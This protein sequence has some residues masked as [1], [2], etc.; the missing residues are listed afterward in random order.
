M[1]TARAFVLVQALLLSMAAAAADGVRCQLVNIAEWPVRLERNLPITEGAINGKKVGILIDTGASV[2]L[3]TKATAMKFDLFTRALPERMVGFGGETTVL[4]ARL[5]EL[6]IGDAARQGM[7]VRVGGER[8]IANVDFILGEDF[9][10]VL[11][12]EFDYAKGVIR[13]FQPKD[14]GNAWLAYWDRD[15]QVLPIDNNDVGRIMVPVKVNGHDASA[16][17]DSG[18]SSSVVSMGLAQRAG[19]TPETPGVSAAHCSQGVGADVV[20]AWVGAFDSVSLAGET[21]RDPRLTFTNYDTDLGRRH[22]DIILGTDFLRAHR[23]YVSRSQGKL[24]FSYTGGLIFPATP[25]IDCDERLAGK[26]RKEVLAA[27]DEAIAKDPKDTK[28]LLNRAVVRLA[29]N[30]TKEAVADLDAVIALEP[31][32]AVALAARAGARTALGDYDGA[33]ADS[34]GSIDNGMRTSSAYVER[35]RIRRAKGDLDGMMQEYDQAL[36]L[37]PL[38][39]AA[40]RQRGTALFAAGRFDAA[41]RDF[42]A[43]AA[44]RPDA[45]VAAWLSYARLR[46][47]EDANAALEAGLARTGDTPWP[48]PM[49][50]YLLGRSDEAALMAA[51]ADP[52]AARQKARECEARFAAAQRHLA[53]GEKAAARDL[54]RQAHESCPRNY[55]EYQA[56]AAELPRLQ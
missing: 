36:K 53:S 47:G 48:R 10:H 34:Q 17:L 14:C 30:E 7:R 42:A 9:L 27:L 31:R 16:M 44:A 18:A 26:D 38:D 21:I 12:V 8:P 13:L 2:S 11:D 32:N 23:V 55:Y 25:S 46:Q 3:L 22:P 50:L 37:D 41:E 39:A 49:L 1:K 52:D 5:D 40:L 33:L 54:L 19:V 35:A 6:K 45:Y 56:A 20:H 51:A 29:Q 15:A 28:A 24:Y 4:M 43:L